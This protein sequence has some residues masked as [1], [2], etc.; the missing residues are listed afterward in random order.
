MPGTDGAQAIASILAANRAVRVLVVTTYDTDRDI[1]RAVEAGAAGYLLKDTPRADLAQAV[2]AAAAGETVLAPP[3]AARLMARSRPPAH[4]DLTPR[5][6]EVLAQVARG[7]TNDE[8][9]RRLFIGGSDGQDPPPPR[10]RQA[11]CR[12]PHRGRDRRHLPG[13]PGPSER[14]RRVTGARWPRSLPAP[15]RDLSP[16]RNAPVESWEPRGGVGDTAS[17]GLG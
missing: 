2:R 12:R 10:L 1:L 9:G 8:I 7:F 4:E 11:W 5:E 15:S 13:H 17:V 14:S 6:A 3:V 16:G